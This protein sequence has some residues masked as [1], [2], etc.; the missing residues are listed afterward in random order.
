[1]GRRRLRRQRLKVI[2]IRRIV[3][4]LV[5]LGG[6]C[7]GLSALRFS[8]DGR[9]EL[10]V[11]LLAAAAIIDGMDGRLARLLNSTSAFGAQLDSLS[12]FLCFG[13]SPPFVL[14]M[15]KLHE[16]KG[17]GWACVLFFTVCCALRLAR[18]NTALN[19]EHAPWEAKFF[20]GIPSPSGAMLSLMPIVYSFGYTGIFDNVFFCIIWTTFMGVLMASKI[21]TFAAKRLRVPHDWLLPIMLGLGLVM[22][23]VFIEPWV[24]F[25]I[26]GLIYCAFVPVSIYSYRKLVRLNRQIAAITVSPAASSSPELHPPAAE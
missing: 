15:W 21:P 3:P 17:L 13:V 1:M 6:L 24:M 16:I 20:V 5:T 25:N 8:V 18:F 2:P 9:F 12:D 23:F 22:V 26:C 4:N 11:A 19:T 10:A 7:C 14:Y